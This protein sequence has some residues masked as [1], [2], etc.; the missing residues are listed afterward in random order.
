MML[1]KEVLIVKG[2]VR[3]EIFM[4]SVFQVNGM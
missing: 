3:S 1:F 2:W 4:K